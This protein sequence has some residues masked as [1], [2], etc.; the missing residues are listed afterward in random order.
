MY[1]RPFSFSKESIMLKNRISYI[2]VAAALLVMA[3]LPISQTAAVAKVVSNVASQGVAVTSP[4]PSAACPFSTQD[5]QSLRAVYMPD[6]GIWLPRTGRG[7]AGL[8]GGVLCLLNCPTA[9]A[10]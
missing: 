6:M 8:D 1:V 9:N 7:D 2:V 5:L 4:L 3:A 10:R